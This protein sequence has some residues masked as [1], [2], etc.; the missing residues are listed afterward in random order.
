MARA[1][2]VVKQG[3]RPASDPPC[4]PEPPPPP[5]PLSRFVGRQTTLAELGRWLARGCRL[6]TVWGPGGM[7]KTRVA[8]EVARARRAAGETVLYVPLAEVRDLASACGAVA[9]ACGVNATGDGDAALVEMVGRALASKGP[10]LVVLDN[11]EHLL[12]EIAGAVEAWLARAVS[13]RVLATSRERTNVPGEAALELLPLTLPEGDGAAASEAVELFLARVNEQRPADPLGEE[14]APRVAELVR[15]LE[16]IPLAIELAAARFDVVGLEGLLGRLGRRLDL[17]GKPRRAGDPRTTT[18]RGAVEWSWSLLPDDER[19]ALSR[20]SIFPA[21]FTIEAA[22]HVLAGLPGA[23]IDLV[24]AL[25]DKSLLRLLSAHDALGASR[26]ALYEGVREL[27]AEKLAQTPGEAAL[28]ARLFAEHTLAAGEEAAARFS[29]TGDVGALESIAREQAHLAAVAE[30]APESSEALRALVVLDPVVMTRGPAA[31]HAERLDVAIRAVERA[32]DATWLAK[33][34]GARGRARMFR[35]RTDEAEADLSRALALAEAW[36]DRLLEAELSADLGVLAHRRG[37]LARAEALY[38][39]ALT[40]DRAAGGSR[41]EGRVLGNLGALHHDARRPEQA[42]EHYERALSILGIHGDKRL[43]GI[44][45][46]NLGTLEQEQGAMLAAKRRFDRAAT[47]LAEVFDLR[48]YGITLTSLGLLHHEEG[49]LEEARFCHEQALQKLVVAGDRR[50][51]ALAFVR[52]GALLASLG[53]ADEARVALH[54]GERASDGD[55]VVQAAA[56]LAAGFLDLLQ[57]RRAR[58][59]RRPEAASAHLAKAAA[60]MDRARAHSDGSP[61]AAERSDDVRTL[62]RILSRGAT[63]VLGATPEPAPAPLG[64][65]APERALLLSPES[66]WLRIPGGNWLDLRRKGPARRLLQKLVERQREAPGAGVSLD[67]LREAGWPG[68]RMQPSAAANRIYVALHQLRSMGLEDR[69]IRTADGYLLDP[70]LP[71][72]HV[73]IEPAEAEIK[74][75]AG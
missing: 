40:V 49:R 70:T 33:G 25:R 13:A 16:G 9:R 1:R 35:G 4:A 22:A 5:A 63:A 31:G 23:A 46:T 14:A 3:A 15:A 36:G 57:A 21:S 8:I 58:D 61:S 60:R 69:V 52:L 53:L 43:L 71:V 72:Y 67:D 74:A 37:D 11:L 75:G 66:R 47:L 48:L 56:D 39:R 54:R 50:S 42:I 17:L 27:G 45:S 10:A 30:R 24:Q 41:T 26:L 59:E 18:L 29:R 2:K 19:A 6:V 28:A 62:L 51:E 64:E 12:P 44:V 32:N 55:A 73:A 20:C 38:E 68:E 34:L 7:G 65:G